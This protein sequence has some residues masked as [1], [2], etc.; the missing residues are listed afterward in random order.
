[1]LKTEELWEQQQ[2]EGNGPQLRIG[3]PSSLLL[4]E[5]CAYGPGNDHRKCQDLIGI[6]LS[7]KTGI[8]F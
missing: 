5:M 1:M 7:F 3:L 2:Q 4:V 6:N 8:H